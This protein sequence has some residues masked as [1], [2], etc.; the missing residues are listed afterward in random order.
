M[1]RGLTEVGVVQKIS[2]MIISYASGKYIP[3]YALE[4]YCRWETNYNAGPWQDLAKLSVG[5]RS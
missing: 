5:L 2:H 3:S 1:G 4:D